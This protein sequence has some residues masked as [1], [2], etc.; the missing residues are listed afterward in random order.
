MDTPNLL[1][2]PSAYKAGKIY[3]PIPTDGGGDLAFTRASGGT[4]INSSG[5]IEEMGTNVPRLDY[6]GGGCPSW[7]FEPQRTNI[8][9]Y[10]E[11]FTNSAWSKSNATITPNAIIA[12]D[13]TTTGVLYTSTA[14]SDFI[15][16]SPSLTVS[17]DYLFSL[18]AK[19]RT[20]NVI[21]LVG[22]GTAFTTAAVVQFDLTTQQA[23][24]IQ[25]NVAN[26][27]IVRFGDWYR[28]SATFTPDLIGSSTIRI[29]NATNDNTDFYIWG[30]QIEQG[31][32]PTSYIKTEAT[33]VTRV[34]DSAFKTGISNLIGDSEG[35]IFFEGSYFADLL[36]SISIDDGTGNNR[37]Q[38]DP[39]VGGIR[40][41][42]TSNGVNVVTQS[43]GVLPI[44]E[45]V[46]IVVTY[47][48]SGY[49][50]WLNGNKL[51][52]GNSN[53]S[54]TA[55]ALTSLRFSAF[56]SSQNFY[57]NVKKLA[58]WDTALTDSEAQ[59]ITK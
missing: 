56:N 37:V 49:S 59:E 2:I 24:I 1:N 13:G 40:L 46:K 57:G 18:F 21:S 55:G 44:N 23:T 36:Y 25:G 3:S 14:A 4:R 16:Q 8:F 11:D 32:Y 52:S 17:E 50:L 7:L 33:A 20:N 45:T 9:K 39:P 5:I 34:A 15:S 26:V 19:A 43:N 12:P 53:A 35:T 31:S 29:Q 42:I 30:A 38:F 28:I 22:T 27:S 54:F 51:I 41:L 58:L 10:S 48:A 6:S 47:S